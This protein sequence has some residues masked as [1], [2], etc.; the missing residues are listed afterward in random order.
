MSF[1]HA[2][3]TVVF[4]GVKS[5]L[6]VSSMAVWEIVTCLCLTHPCQSLI[7]IVYI[8]IKQAP[9]VRLASRLST[10]QAV[11]I[12]VGQS[13]AFTLAEMHIFISHKPVSIE[14]FLVNISGSIRSDVE[15]F[16]RKPDG[17]SM[18]S[19]SSDF[20]GALLVNNTNYLH[21]TGMW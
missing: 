10:V 4:F 6:V 3:R 9:T 18:R 15:N 7:F 12:L 16:F 5:R 1:A 11:V 20:D 2:S 21:G 13:S 19:D 8:Y 17:L 14:R